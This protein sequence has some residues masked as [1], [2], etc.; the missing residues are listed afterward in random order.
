MRKRSRNA[1]EISSAKNKK[2]D[3]NKIAKKRNE[4]F[5]RS[6]TEFE[7]FAYKKKIISL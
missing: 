7:Y 6:L 4:R 3:K 5:R 1:I 2:S